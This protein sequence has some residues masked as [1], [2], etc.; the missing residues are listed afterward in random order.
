LENLG[1][2]DARHG[3][4]Q[5]KADRIKHWIE[6]GA[7]VSGTVHNL[8]VEA[9]IVAG[10]KRNVLPKKRP[11]VKAAEAAPAAAP[12]VTETPTAEAPVSETP[13]EVVA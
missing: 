1:S 6:H 9:K 3:A 8:L 13:S 2:Y 10:P 11:I 5:L 7:Q 12:E 4:P